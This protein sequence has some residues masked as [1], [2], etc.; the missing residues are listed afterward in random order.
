MLGSFLP[1]LQGGSSC[2]ESQVIFVYKDLWQLGTADYGSW[3]STA[4]WLV[5]GG[6]L[7]LALV[8][9]N[10][11]GLPLLRWLDPWPW[12]LPLIATALIAVGTLG[13]HLPPAL[14]LSPECSSSIALGLGKRVCVGGSAIGVVATMWILISSRS[15]KHANSD[16]RLQGV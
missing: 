3:Y 15:L 11:L 16:P 4:L 9:T 6:A 1:W 2:G 8:G 12:A 5:V 13:T 10:A 14:Q 7:I